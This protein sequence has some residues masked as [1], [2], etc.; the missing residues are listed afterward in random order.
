M[1]TWVKVTV[2][3]IENWIK[4]LRYLINYEDSKLDLHVANSY[5]VVS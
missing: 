2:N 3:L 4:Y 1:L 5:L